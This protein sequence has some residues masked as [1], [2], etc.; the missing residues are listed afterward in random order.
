MF[1]NYADDPEKVKQ[2]KELLR[3]VEDQFIVWSDPPQIP[4]RTE[5]YWPA[6]SYS[7]DNWLFPCVCEQYLFWQPVNASS[8]KTISAFV[9][10]YKDNRRGDLSEQG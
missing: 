4:E 1:K 10:A 9:Q 6:E 7:P 5:S 8:A 3:F 2:A